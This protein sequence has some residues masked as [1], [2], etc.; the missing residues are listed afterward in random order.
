MVDLATVLFRRLI[1]M[2]WKATAA[3][4][5]KCWLRVVLKWANAEA[6]IMLRAQHLR[7]GGGAITLWDTYVLKLNNMVDELTGK[8]CG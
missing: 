6:D 5:T 2:A 4:D 3:P 8:S 1:A 7:G